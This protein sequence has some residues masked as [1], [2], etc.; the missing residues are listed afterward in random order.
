MESDFS[1]FIKKVLIIGS[2]GAMGS[3]FMKLFKDFDL[4][5]YGVDKPLKICENHLDTDIIL[6]ASL[7]ELLKMF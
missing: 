4:Q 6:F 2:K 5:V 3:F 7:W 1:D